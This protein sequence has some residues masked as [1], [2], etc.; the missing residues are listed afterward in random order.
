MISVISATPHGSDPARA[1]VDLA[2]WHLLKRYGLD[3]EVR[4]LRAYSIEEARAV[5]GDEPTNRARLPFEHGSLRDQFDSV[6][7]SDAIVLWGDGLH[8]RAHQDQLATVM[9]DLGAA[10]SRDEAIRLV[11][12]LTMLAGSSEDVLSRVILAGGGLLFNRASDYADEDYRDSLT[13]LARGAHAHLMR[14]LHSAWRI[15]ELR[16][17]AGF[18]PGVDPVALLT[19]DAIEGL[20]RTEYSD[21]DPRGRIGLFFGRSYGEL[22]GVGTFI[23]ILGRHLDREVEWLAWGRTPYFRNCKKTIRPEFRG[24]KKRMKKV[25]PTLGDLLHLVGRYDLILTDTYDVAVHAWR[26]GVP[27]VCVADTRPRRG[28]DPS[29]GHH[30]AWRDERQLFYSTYDALPFFVYRDELQDP[31]SRNQRIA[32]LEDL[33]NDGS[34]VLHV[35]RQLRDH[36]SR[37]EALLVKAIEERTGRK[38]RPVGESPTGLSRLA[39]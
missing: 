29:C 34:E 18:A 4:F 6:L 20:D 19:P 16:G 5:R 12:R 27:A 26:S 33:L 15:A 2:F 36:A 38:A 7:D 24:M 10:A 9:I 1:A 22:E 31:I 35:A 17:E 8:G 28:S 30:L 23:R 39:T 21:A 3:E 37:A 13:R 14:D 11:R 32:R 25:R